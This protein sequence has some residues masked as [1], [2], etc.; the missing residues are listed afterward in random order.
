MTPM[1]IS[2]RYFIPPALLVVLCLAFAAA[3][4]AALNVHE[5]THELKAEQIMHWPLRAGDSLIF[6]PCGEC[7]IKTL[8]VTDQTR[9]A[10]GFGTAPIPLGELL[11]QKSLLRKGTE[12]VIAVFYLPKEQQITRLILQTEF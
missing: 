7:A 12:H 1:Q 9:F 2:T 5:E 10:T 3:G 8:K 6:R 11:R 4:Q